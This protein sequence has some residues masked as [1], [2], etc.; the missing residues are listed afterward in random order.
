MARL[1]GRRI[2]NLL[3]ANQA[4]V[5]TDT[6][7][8]VGLSGMTVARSTAEALHG[9]ASLLATAATAGGCFAGTPRGSSGI[10]VTPGQTY[11]AL[12]AVKNGIG[13][14]PWLLSLVYRTA[15]AAYVGGLLTPTVVAADWAVLVVTAVA[16]PGAEYANIEVGAND[17]GA[18]GD[19]VYIDC[20]SIHRGAG[21]EWVLPGV[22]VPNLGIRANPA[23]AA[24]VQIWN[25]GN[26]TWI[27]V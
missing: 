5:E 7:G 2:G 21:G 12:V 1:T 6:V 18:V 4:S 14:R 9:E 10:P 17:A 22:P 13:T 20:L 27:T 15:A 3:S 25:P 11:T 23:N 24:Q 8:L 16:P 26:E 19:S